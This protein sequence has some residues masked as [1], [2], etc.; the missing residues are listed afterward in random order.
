LKILVS[1]VRSRPTPLVHHSFSEGGLNLESFNGNVE[2]LLLLRRYPPIAC[3]LSFRKGGISKI[4]PKMFLLVRR[5]KMLGETT[6]RNAMCVILNNN[7]PLAF[8]PHLYT[9]WP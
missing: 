5:P 3:H 2:A 1:P 9:Q 7:Y 4:T 8:A 6:L